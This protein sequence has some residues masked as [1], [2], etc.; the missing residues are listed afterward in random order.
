MSSPAST[1]SYTRDSHTI[2][3]VSVE[4]NS[5]VNNNNNNNNLDNNNNTS[6]QFNETPATTT[7]STSGSVGID[8]TKY[9]SLLDRLYSRFDSDNALRP[10]ILEVDNHWTKKS[11]PSLLLSPK[12]DSLDKDKLRDEKNNAFDLLDAL[13][14]S[15]LS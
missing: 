2:P 5:S 7:T 11:Q 9:P 4:I 8:Y 3:G 12:T 15:G 6:Q 13:S 1:F 10:T 14:K